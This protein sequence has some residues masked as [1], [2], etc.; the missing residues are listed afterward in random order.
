MRKVIWVSRVPQEPQVFQALL[1]PKV[2]LAVQVSQVL[3]VLM[4]L[5]VPEDPLDPKVL[6]VLLV[7][8]D[9]QVFLVPL[10]LLV[11]LQKVFPD[12]RAPLASLVSLV[13]MGNL[14]KLVL[15][16]PLVLLVRLY[17]RKEWVW[18][19]L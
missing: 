1:D 5:Q 11:W 12:L 7:L 3:L 6:L 18:A 16:D 15:L 17:S 2:I 8:R 19:R 13:L 14:V 9:I 10:A 4:V